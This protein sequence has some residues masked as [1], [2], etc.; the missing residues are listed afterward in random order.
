MGGGNG[1]IRRIRFLK[2]MTAAILSGH[3]IVKPFGLKG[4]APG[5]TGKSYVERIDGVKEILRG[6]DQIEINSGDIFTIETPGGGGY[7]SKD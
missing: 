1:T 6:A 2:P 5:K 4:G 7:G 3:R